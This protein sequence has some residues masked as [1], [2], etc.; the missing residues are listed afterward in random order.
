MCLNYV[1]RFF[2]YSSTFSLSILWIEYLWNVESQVYSQSFIVSLLHNK[3]QAHWPP[4]IA[5]EESWS[6][7]ALSRFSFSIL[8]K[9]IE[10]LKILTIWDNV[11]DLLDFTAAPGSWDHF[12]KQHCFRG[13]NIHLM[14][15]THSVS[16]IKIFLR[17]MCWCHFIEAE[18][19]A[20]RSYLLEI[21]DQ[22]DD[23]AGIEPRLAW[24]YSILPALGPSPHR[25]CTSS[26]Q[27][28]TAYLL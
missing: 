6:L 24:L 8:W 11:T 3:W 25:G 7:F 23:K 4:S 19:E 20:L 2:K 16:L 1:S 15:F 26:L 17:L 12:L 21:I 27:T 9:K 14:Y 22:L 5:G 13:C 28:Q 18:T 10:N